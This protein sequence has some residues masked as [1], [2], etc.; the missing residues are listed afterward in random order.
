MV[1]LHLLLPSLP[2]PIS[3]PFESMRQK[4]I[5]PSRLLHLYQLAASAGWR[6]NENINNS[7][8][9]WSLNLNRRAVWLA[10]PCWA[11][12]I[13]PVYWHISVW[14]L[15]KYSYW[16]RRQTKHVEKP[17]LAHPSLQRHSRSTRMLVSRNR[18]RYK[19]ISHMQAWHW[20]IKTF[21]FPHGKE[22]DVSGALC[23]ANSHST[24]SGCP[25][26]DTH[27]K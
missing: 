12:I 6:A 14:S 9:S 13:K 19:F 18:K 15:F 21:F 5:F 22:A 10:G 1:R 2:S 11:A 7:G 8:G 26:K 16:N 24:Q 27:T 23:A 25:I 3:S 4:C 17:K 20:D